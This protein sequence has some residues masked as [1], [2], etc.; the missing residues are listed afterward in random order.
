MAGLHLYCIHVHTFVLDNMRRPED[1]DPA[2]AHVLFGILDYIA[3]TVHSNNDKLNKLEKD[4]QSCRNL[5]EELKQ[6]I[7]S[8]SK[9]AFN[10]KEQNY[11]VM[12]IYFSIL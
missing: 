1:R 5:Q 2:R 3:K 10:L 12:I 9:S 8:M 7:M 11:E 4:I 6:L